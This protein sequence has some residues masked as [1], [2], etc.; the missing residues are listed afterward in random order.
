MFSEHWLQYEAKTL[1]RMDSFEWSVY[2]H[3]LAALFCCLRVIRELHHLIHE[4]DV[5]Y[6]TVHIDVRVAT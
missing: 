5:T 6:V 4:S 2:H 1:H 3:R